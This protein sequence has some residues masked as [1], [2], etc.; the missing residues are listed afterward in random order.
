MDNQHL[1]RNSSRRF[2]PSV[3]EGS[4]VGPCEREG[5]CAGGTGWRQSLFPPARETQRRGSGAER[6]IKAGKRGWERRGGAW[7]G[8]LTRPGS[9]YTGLG[10]RAS[11]CIPPNPPPALA[12]YLDSAALRASGR[13]SSYN[14]APRRCV[15]ESWRLLPGRVPPP[16]DRCSRVSPEQ[17]PR[18]P[19][20]QPTWLAWDCL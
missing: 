3:S 13:A 7:G 18:T 12:V 14:R 19:A 8:G 17:L 15:S 9:C 11:P 16:G 6:I 5:L 20:L 10:A 4:E 2:P 1:G